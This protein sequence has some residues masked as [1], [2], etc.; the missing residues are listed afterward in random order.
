MF[1]S[2]ATL[3]LPAACSKMWLWLGPSSVQAERSSSATPLTPS[4]PACIA[5]SPNCAKAGPRT[6]R[7]CS[8]HRCGWPRCGHWS[9]IVA[10][11]AISLAS[12][13]RGHPRPATV[14]GILCVTL[15]VFFLARIRRAHF[16]W[17]ANILSLFGLPLFSYLLLRSAK[18]HAN[19]S[20]PWKGRTYQDEPCLPAEDNAQLKAG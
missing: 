9:L 3:P 17:D 15:Y 18:A 1:R 8:P 5:A 11:F 10:S 4:A 14:A 7:C 2:A 12:S 13:L 16:F 19:G 20:V 6:S